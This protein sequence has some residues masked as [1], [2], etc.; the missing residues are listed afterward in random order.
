MLR[1][2]FFINLILIIIIGFLGLK[3]HKSYSQKMDM[4]AGPAAKQV[5][6]KDD[7]VKKEDK[8][9]DPSLFQIISNMDIFRP[10]RSPYREEE[11]KQEA[12]KIPPRLFGTVILGNE[13]TALLED[14]NTK[15][16]RIYRVNESVGGYVVSEIMEDRVVLSWNGDK[17]EIRLREEKKG[18]PPV[19]QMIIP[20]PQQP[21]VP[22]PQ[23]QS[24]QVQPPQQVVPPQPSVIPPP[25]PRQR[26]VPARPQPLP[27][28]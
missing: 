2:Y 8:P 27:L 14:P 23:Q 3:F 22:Q 1:N 11:A 26:R 24:P 13:K 6:K 20:Q 9:V 10:S 5:Q 19:K 15:S 7:Q 21:Q 28:R 12:P 16:T 17:S 18:L 4:P 25:S